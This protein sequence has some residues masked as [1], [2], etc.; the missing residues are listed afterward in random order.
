M[1]ARGSS[2][3]S[4]SGSFLLLT[5]HPVDLLEHSVSLRGPFP[6]ISGRARVFSFLP[7]LILPYL[8]LARGVPSMP[9]PIQPYLGLASVFSFLPGLILPFLGREGLFRLLRGQILH[10]SGP[11]GDGLIVEVRWS[12]VFGAG[13]GK[14]PARIRWFCVICVG[15]DLISARIQ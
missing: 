1:L 11:V 15:N 5:V 2:F 6:P 9:V 12:T 14:Y 4:E 8:C 13:N 3:M 10:Y 7:G